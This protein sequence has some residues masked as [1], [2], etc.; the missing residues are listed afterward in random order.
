MHYIQ[1]A[2]AQSCRKY[3]L[4]RIKSVILASDQLETSIIFSASHILV[5]FIDSWLSNDQEMVLKSS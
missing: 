4:I 2:K 5:R 1:F 3:H